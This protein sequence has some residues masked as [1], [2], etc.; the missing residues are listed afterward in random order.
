MV[1]A[2]LHFQLFILAHSYEYALGH[3][4]FW[5]TFFNFLGTLRKVV[6][7]LPI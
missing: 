4:K 5:L 3:T 7:Q 2:D 1:L 6:V